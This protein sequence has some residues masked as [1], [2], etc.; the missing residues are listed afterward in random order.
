MGEFKSRGG[1][2]WVRGIMDCLSKETRSEVQVLGIEWET[3]IQQ[4]GS[5]E[6]GRS[7][8]QGGGSCQVP[9]VPQHVTHALLAQAPLRPGEDKERFLGVLVALDGQSRGGAVQDGT[10]RDKQPIVDRGQG[11]TGEQQACRAQ[12]ASEGR[13]CISF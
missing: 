8:L 4:G 12:Q 1:G 5:H 13:G 9:L 7:G 2:E 10:T 6:G 3:D 11:C